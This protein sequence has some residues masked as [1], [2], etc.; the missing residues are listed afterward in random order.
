MVAHTVLSQLTA[1]DQV[2]VDLARPSMPANISALTA[3]RSSQDEYAC[4]PILPA[5][6]AVTAIGHIVHRLLNWGNKYSCGFNH[7]IHLLH[8]MHA[9]TNVLHSNQKLRVTGL[10]AHLWTPA[11]MSFIPKADLIFHP[12]TEAGLGHTWSSAT[13]A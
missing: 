2:Q 1:S 3:R 6:P 10:D 4:Q 8:H 11:T 7:K 13:C 5:L 12:E 9:A